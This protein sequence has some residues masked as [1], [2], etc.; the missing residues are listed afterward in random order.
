MLYEEGELTQEQADRIIG[1]KML[2]RIRFLNK[3]LSEHDYH[4]MFH[5]TYT[6][7]IKG[8]FADGL[9]FIRM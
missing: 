5:S 4:L 7:N 6:S 3:W 1:D 9:S 2:A 8:I